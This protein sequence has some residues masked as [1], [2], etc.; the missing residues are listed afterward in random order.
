M[1][2]PAVL[3]YIDYLKEDPVL[4][5]GSEDK[6]PEMKATDLYQHFRGWCSDNGERN[7]PTTTKFGVLAQDHLVKKHT[8]RGNVYVLP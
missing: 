8:K 6:L 5:P 2:K 1:S 3:K 7:I 4:V